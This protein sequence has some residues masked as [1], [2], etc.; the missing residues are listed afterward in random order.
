[1]ALRRLERKRDI[2]PDWWW[3]QWNVGLSETGREWV[4]QQADEDAKAE[5]LLRFLMAGSSDDDETEKARRL[6]R[7]LGLIG[8]DR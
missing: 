8:G 3:R 2:P 4:K 6:A 1:M 7:A 5:R